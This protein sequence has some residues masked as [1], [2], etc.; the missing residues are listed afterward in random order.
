MFGIKLQ[1]SPD[2]VNSVGDASDGYLMLD[3]PRVGANVMYLWDFGIVQY[4][5]IVFQFCIYTGC[6]PAICKSISEISM[7]KIAAGKFYLS[8]SGS[9]WQAQMYHN[10]W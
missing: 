7:I 1:P 3:W 8:F 9:E 5:V 4:C 6:L 10:G 2:D